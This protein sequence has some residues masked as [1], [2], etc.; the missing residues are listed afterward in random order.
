MS[1]VT[2][3]R[4]FL[5]PT[6]YYRNANVTVAKK[7]LPN[8]STSINSYDKDGRLLKSIIREP[9]DKFI[10]NP[11]DGNMLRYGHKT[12]VKDHV[13]NTETIIDKYA[14][15]FEKP[16]YDALNPTKTL[17]DAGGSIKYFHKF[18]KNAKGKYID[19]FNMTINNNGRAGVKVL[20]DGNGTPVSSVKYSAKKG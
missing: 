8:G 10:Y 3:I 15:R 7:L 17:A 1:L 9:V 2:A 13:A 5:T 20:Y 16:V 6:K 14:K 12:T 19:S 4:S 18:T 11:L